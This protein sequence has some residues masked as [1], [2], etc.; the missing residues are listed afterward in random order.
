MK[1]GVHLLDGIRNSVLGGILYWKFVNSGGFPVNPKLVYNFLAA[2][3][4]PPSPALFSCQSR[5]GKE[6][7]YLNGVVKLKCNLSCALGCYSCHQRRY[8]VTI[9]LIATFLLVTSY[10]GIMRILL[11]TAYLCVTICTPTEKNIKRIRVLQNYAEYNKIT[12]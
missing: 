2:R 6:C 8:T 12:Q 10:Y 3:R 5:F 7:R 9:L 1:P 11:V 4:I